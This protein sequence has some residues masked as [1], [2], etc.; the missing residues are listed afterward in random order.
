M[1]FL[2]LF[3]QIF[4][5]L[6]SFVWVCSIWFVY[7]DT[8]WHK[9]QAGPLATLYNLNMDKKMASVEDPAAGASQDN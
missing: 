6:A 7:K 8:A 1:P 4:G 2:S 3:L 9:D 5:W